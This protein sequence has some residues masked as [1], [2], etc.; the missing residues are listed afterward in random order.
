MKE[1]FKNISW[2]IS[3]IIVVICI[4]GIVI[5]K[6]TPKEKAIGVSNTVI[7]SLKTHNG[8]DFGKIDMTLINK[9]DMGSIFTGLSIF[10]YKLKSTSESDIYETYTTYKV[11]QTDSEFAADVI[12]EEGIHLGDVN[13]QWT[14]DKSIDNQVTFISGKY[15]VKQYNVTY[16]VNYS[17][18]D[19]NKKERDITVVTQEQTHNKNNFKVM[20][21]IGIN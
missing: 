11:N 20:D 7:K 10:D 15:K 17:A 8:K 9:M 5:Y 6:N 16:D 19:G 12:T 13:G 14:E 3:I 21:I 4:V 18:S 1:R 2:V